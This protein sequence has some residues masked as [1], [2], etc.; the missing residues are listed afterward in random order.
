MVM[1]DADKLANNTHEIADEKKSG[2]LKKKYLREHTITL[3]DC[4][5]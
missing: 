1:C 3:T 5:V 2:E 4:L